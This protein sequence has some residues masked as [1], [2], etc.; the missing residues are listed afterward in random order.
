M[1]TK[2]EL[3]RIAGESRA[4][5]S[6][7]ER[8]KKSEHISAQLYETESY[9]LADAVAVYVSVGSEADTREI[10]ERAMQDGKHLFC[11]KV[12][13]ASSGEMEFYEI[14]SFSDLLPPV[15]KLQIPEPEGISLSLTAYVEE[16]PSGRVLFLVPGLAFN[17]QGARIGY[18]GGFYDRY[19][20]RLLQIDGS[21]PKWMD[22]MA[23]SFACQVY[24]ESFPTEETDVRIL[25]ILTEG[26]EIVC[27]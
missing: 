15:G 4:A 17:T 1:R 18:G 21:F 5:L 9:R 7:R 3:R 16:Y 11:P 2:A 13:D 26:G 14:T 22:V 23:I 20:G 12:T 8:R 19:L 24:T 25:R 10:M 27:K 6:E